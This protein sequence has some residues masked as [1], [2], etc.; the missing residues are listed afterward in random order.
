MWQQ[1]G[2]LGEKGQDWVLTEHLQRAFIEFEDAKSRE[3]LEDINFVNT[4]RGKKEEEVYDNLMQK[5]IMKRL[6]FMP[7]NP[8]AAQQYRSY[9]K[10]R[11]V[12][13]ATQA[14]NRRGRAGCRQRRR[15]HGQACRDYRS[16]Y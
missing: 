3:E 16:G 1:I 15:R 6:S 5:S 11:Q 13:L 10:E 2:R 12:E 4:L 8:L 9:M 14:R 7:K